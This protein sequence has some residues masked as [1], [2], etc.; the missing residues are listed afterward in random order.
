MTS[1]RRDLSLAG[2]TADERSS[3]QME[4]RPGSGVSDRPTLFDG[5]PESTWTE[6]H[7]LLQ[8]A[9]P[10]DRMLVCLGLEA[11]PNAVRVAAVLAYHGWTSWPSRETLAV[12][13]GLNPQNVSRATSELEKTG[14]LHRRKR[15]HKRGA[16][17]IQHTFNG[18]AIAAAAARQDHPELGDAAR[19]ILAAV[20]SG[21]NHCRNQCESGT[22]GPKNQIDSGV[23]INLSTE[24]ESEPGSTELRNDDLIDVSIRQ[25]SG[26]VDGGY[27]ARRDYARAEGEK[28]HHI[29][30]S[31]EFGHG[32]DRANSGC[33]TP[34]SV[35]GHE[36]RPEWFS[37][38]RE[39][40]SGEKVPKFRLLDEAR[41]LA[42]WTDEVL[43]QAARSYASYYHDKQVRDPLKLFK[44]VA[45]QAASELPA[46]GSKQRNKYLADYLWLKDL[47]R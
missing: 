16:V 18:M 46:S 32:D 13:T 29:C 22:D 26:S 14:I 47:R 33:G 7:R 27:D 6:A 30:G 35:E 5:L 1:R 17:G 37:Y 31:P 38:L 34:D 11:T 3:A 43:F 36:S 20:A 45:A 8:D 44:K 23:G 15:P 10:G 42:G 40:V 2:E 21:D 28:I 41:K 24:P 39:N 9:R 12:R 4:G 19:Q 25:S